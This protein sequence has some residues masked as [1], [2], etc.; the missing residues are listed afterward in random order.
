MGTN[1]EFVS[2]FTSLRITNSTKELRARTE[3]GGVAHITG[4]T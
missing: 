2:V 1:G 3:G 4:T